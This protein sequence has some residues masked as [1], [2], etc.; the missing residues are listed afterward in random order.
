MGRGTDRRDCVVTTPDSDA[1]WHK[2]CVDGRDL[3]VAEF[4]NW[5]AEF[6]NWPA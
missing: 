3:P 2:A 1:G 6:L 5:P 4:G